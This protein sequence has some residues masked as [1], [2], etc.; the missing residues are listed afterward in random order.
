LAF[1]T[2]RKIDMQVTLINNPD[3]GNDGQPFRVNTIEV[4]AK[5]YALQFLAA[6]QVL[7]LLLRGGIL[8]SFAS[9]ILTRA[10]FLARNSK[11]VKYGR[12][13]HKLPA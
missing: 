2:E 5:R 13:C 12:E 6:R 7:A 10:K 3:T 8:Q 11:Y 1:I 4:T 9:L